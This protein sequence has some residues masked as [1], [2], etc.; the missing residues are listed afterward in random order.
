MPESSS[1]LRR[2]SIVKKIPVFSGLNW[3]RIQSI[4]SSGEVVCY[5]KG[6]IVSRKGQAPDF[7]YFLDSGRLQSYSLDASGGKDDLEF[8]HRGMF[9]GIISTL[10]GEEHSQTFEAINDSIIFRIP[11]AV[12]RKI[13]KQSPRLGV[14]FTKILSQRIRSKVTRTELVSRS[15]II[16]VYA[17][18]TGSGGSTFAVNLA[19]SLAR[20]TGKRVVWVSIRSR[21]MRARTTMAYIDEV[22]PKWTRD[23]Q[24]IVTLADNFEIIPQH[25]VKTDFG[26]DL[27]NVTFDQDDPSIVEFISEFVSRFIDEYRYVILDLPSEMDAVV[28]KTLSQSDLVYL[29]MVRK[30]EAL[31]VGRAVLDRVEE[32]FKEGFTE[33]RVKVVISGVY[34][35]RNISENAVHEMLD[36]NITGFLPHIHRKDFSGM[37]D[38]CA[39]SVMGL[40][41]ES[42]YSK[43]I[44]RIARE[45]SGVSIGLVLGGGAAF[46]LAHIG[47]LKVLEEEG[48]PIDIIAGSSMGALI[49]SLWAAGY[50]SADIEKMAYQFRKKSNLIKLIDLVFPISGIISGKAVMSWLRGKFGKRTFRD[51]NIPLKIVAYDLIHRR[52]LV[53]DEG[54]IVEAIR[55]SISIPGVFQPVVSRDQLI[56]DGGVMNPLPTDVLVRAGVRRIIAVN[57]LQSPEDVIKGYEKTSRDLEKSMQVQFIQAP[58]E[59]ISIRIKLWISHKFFPNIS[60]IMVRTLEASESTLAVQSGRIADVLIHPDLSGLNWYDLHQAEALI[61]QGEAAARASLDQLRRVVVNPEQQKTA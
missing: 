51:T 5:K 19:M 11:S 59:Y 27:L 48:I 45:I 44:T 2:C 25:I 36:Y 20:Q 42:N 31:A 30:R 41:S 53:I 1:F 37:I 49:A 15:V 54:S 38:L 14:K 12:F 34:A 13:L 16:S 7:I 26:I 35:H 8:I 28:M 39:A 47:V 24:D 6:D 32:S 60:D 18:I 43:V 46:G 50:R 23:P 9:F 21:A 57:V 56:I 29:V 40:D 22:R 52:D 33:D 55:K 3:Y 17:P 10:T 61:K 58:L 4:A